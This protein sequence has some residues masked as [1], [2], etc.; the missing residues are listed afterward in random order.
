MEQ[1]SNPIS[2]LSWYPKDSPLVQG[3]SGV[4]V[5]GHITITERIRDGSDILPSNYYEG[6]VSK[7]LM[8]ILLHTLIRN[9]RY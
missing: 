6:R 8:F 9:V 5:N 1:L 3:L 4:T 2:T 7:T